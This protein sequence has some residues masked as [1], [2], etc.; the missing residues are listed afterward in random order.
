MVSNIRAPAERAG[1]DRVGRN[2]VGSSRSSRR[3][4]GS[5]GTDATGSLGGRLGE[6][7]NRP[8]RHRRA[9]RRGRQQPD[10]WNVLAE[11]LVSFIPP[12]RHS[13]IRLRF[14]ELACRIC[15]AVRRQA[16]EAEP[17]LAAG[18]S[19][20]LAR[21]GHRTRRGTRGGER[22]APPR[23]PGPG[24]SPP[25]REGCGASS[26]APPPSRSW[27][28]SGSARAPCRVCTGPSLTVPAASREGSGG[29]PVRR[30][31]GRHA[32]VDRLEAR[33]RRRTRGRSSPS[34]SSSCTAPSSLRA[35]SSS[36]PEAD[37]SAM[38]TG[39]PRS[40]LR[41]TRA[42]PVVWGDRGPGRG[43]SRGGA[44]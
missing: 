13:G 19:S 25:G 28:A 42:L 8:R 32:V 17:E 39:E 9:A 38:R 12:Q 30:P 40:A 6:P 34:S 2:A 41:S 5:T 7:A 18:S 14:N 43:L 22:R 44:G 29:L 31:A 36:C 10:G 20:R 3:D 16:S 11:E 37:L 23:L 35:T 27:R 15:G 24:E 1:S 26:P 33:A 4:S 21:P